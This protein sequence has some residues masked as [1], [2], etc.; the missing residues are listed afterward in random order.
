MLATDSYGEATVALN[1]SL[2]A[3]DKAAE[4]LVTDRQGQVEGQRPQ[5]LGWRGLKLQAALI[6]EEKV[7]TLS[8]STAQIT[9]R[10]ASRLRLNASLRTSNR[11]VHA[12]GAAAGAVSAQEGMAQ[13]RRLVPHLLLARPLPQPRP[14]PRLTATD[15]EIAEIGLTEVAARA[16]HGNALRILRAGFAGNDRART[17]G[18]TDGAAKLVTDRRGRILGAGIVGPAAGELAA[19]FA[20]AIARGTTA[21]QLQELAPPHPTLSEI[22]VQLGRESTAAAAPGPLQQRLLALLRLLP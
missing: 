21:R 15:P 16:R 17:L 7:R 2:A 14:L 18:Q 10:D 9:F 12:I 22:A 4:A 20:L 5:D 8:D 13:A 19:L 6:E 1:K 11:R 3:R